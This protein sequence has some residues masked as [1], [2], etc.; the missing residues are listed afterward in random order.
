MHALPLKGEFE[1]NDIGK[2]ILTKFEQG[3]IGYSD[4]EIMYASI[5]VD[6]LAYT[7]EEAS[8]VLDAYTLFESPVTLE[9]H[10][11]NQSSE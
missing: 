8:G 1:V 9:R 7:N 5:L 3:Q 6:P 11:R 10:I 2:E 4:M